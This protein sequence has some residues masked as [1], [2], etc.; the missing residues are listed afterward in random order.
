MTGQGDCRR[1]CMY[2]NSSS[3]IEAGIDFR[4][5]NQQES[6]SIYYFQL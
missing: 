3:F 6:L 4:L 1:K 5:A 2:S